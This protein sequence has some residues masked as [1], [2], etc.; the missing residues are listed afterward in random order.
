MK[1]LTAFVLTLTLLLAAGC[2]RRDPLLCARY[3]DLSPTQY[4]FE[5]GVFDAGKFVPNVVYAFNYSSGTA[6]RDQVSP[7]SGKLVQ[8]TML[9]LAGDTAGVRRSAETYT[10]GA[11]VYVVIDPK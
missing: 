6:T 3:T 2:A 9:A 5:Q 8:P 4:R 7:V 1:R 11:Q 10:I